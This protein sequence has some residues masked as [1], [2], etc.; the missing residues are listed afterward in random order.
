MKIRL[1]WVEKDFRGNELNKREEIL[2]GESAKSP[3]RNQVAKLIARFHPELI[4]V[5][6]VNLLKSHESGYKWYIK[7]SQLDMN[8]W[9]TI[10][11]DPMPDD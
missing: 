2:C 3:T 11:A 10:Y 4:S 6:R 7:S 1:I 5:T 9:V 8:C